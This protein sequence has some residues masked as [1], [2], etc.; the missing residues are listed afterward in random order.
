[1]QTDWQVQ[2]LSFSF[3]QLEISVRVSVRARPTT[4]EDR[5]SQSSELVLDA[6]VAPGADPLTSDPFGISIELEDR[7]LAAD[8]VS[9]LAVLVLPFLTHLERQLRGGD[10]QWTPRARLARAFRAG[11]AAFRRLNGIITEESSLATP[12]R[13]SIYII[14]RA[15]SL[16]SG[17]W[18][19]NYSIFINRCG[20]S[21]HHSFD[22]STVCHAFATRAEGE[23]YLCGARRRWPSLLQ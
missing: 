11:V 17:G 21:G 19:G 6:S 5:P 23:A 1:M 8:S 20:G 16:P 10:S 7:V 18:T 2:E 22:S 4:T 13:N 15:P 12:Y 14:L 3:E 9:E